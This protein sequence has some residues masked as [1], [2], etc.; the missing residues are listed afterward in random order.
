MD[1]ITPVDN[2]TRDMKTLLDDL[3][4]TDSENIDFEHVKKFSTF[5]KNYSTDL[6]EFIYD[7]KED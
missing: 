3:Y 4:N 6:Q 1:I 7:R 5:S 2:L